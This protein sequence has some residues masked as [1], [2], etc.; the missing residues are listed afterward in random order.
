MTEV[1]SSQEPCAHTDAAHIGRAVYTLNPLRA[2][3]TLILLRQGHEPNVVVL[4]GGVLQ[5]H[6]T[7]QGVRS[8]V[9]EN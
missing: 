6:T 2:L 8:R 3:L 9:N 1:H 7:H 4:L 5:K